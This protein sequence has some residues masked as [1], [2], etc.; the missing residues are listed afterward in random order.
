MSSKSRE[1]EF[2]T[3]ILTG[4]ARCDLITSLTKRTIMK[5]HTLQ[6]TAGIFGTFEMAKGTRAE[7]EAALAKLVASHESDEHFALI[8]NRATP[9]RP[10]YEIV[11]A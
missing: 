5:T 1:K 8:T 4:W 7:C 9:E 11:E 3:F 2:Y 10:I 6:M